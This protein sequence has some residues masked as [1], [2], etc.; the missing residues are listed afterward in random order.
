METLMR[1]SATINSSLDIAEVLVSAMSFVEQLMN[2]EVSSIFEVD[3]EHNELFFRVVR[4]EKADEAKEARMKMGEG[5]V[6]WVGSSGEPVIVEDTRTDRRFSSKVDAITGFKT[7]SVVALPIKN[8]GRLI[9]VLEVLNKRE[10]TPFNREDLQLLAVVAD[11]I[12]IAM[13]NAKLHKRL[14]EKFLLT[15][16]ELKR[17]QEQLL[18]SERLAALG[19]LSQGVAHEVRNPV[20]SIGGFA[21]RLKKILPPD[22]SAVAY[23]DVILKETA[24]L[25]TMVRDIEQYTAMPQPVVKPV[26]L[27][28]LLQ[29]TM[30]LWEKEP[31]L[32]DHLRT[33]LEMLP[34][35]PSIFVDKEQI[36]E[37]I[38]E[39][40]R[41]AKEALPEGG[42]ICVGTCWE[43]NRLAI[44]ITDDG[45]GIASEDLPRVFDPF[46]TAKCRGSG[47]G[48]TKVYRIMTNHGGEVKV[49]SREG[50]GTEVK[51]SIPRIPEG[52][53]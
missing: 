43:G 29:S 2:A 24:R 27:S 28:A 11:Q 39:V 4:G 13:V 37:A 33:S 10:G 3:Q 6:G 44:T 31:G 18:R 16:A 53:K 17:T 47:L 41:N 21:H 49:S 20:V 50:R 23:V 36:V 9:G 19:Q 25:E 51:L 14:E 26:K 35:D 22:G 15:Q 38:I 12:G 7:K 8:K 30:E 40:L 46:F 32:V 52:E 34:E 5:I 1:L 45:I 48:L 42:T